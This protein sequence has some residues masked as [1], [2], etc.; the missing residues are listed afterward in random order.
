[1]T[2]SVPE[3]SVLGPILWNSLIDDLLRLPMHDTTKIICFADDIL[4]TT[5]APGLWH[6]RVEIY[7]ALKRVTKWLELK[8]LKVAP[9]K[10]KL[11][12]LTGKRRL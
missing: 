10:T 9:D 8:G 4:I 2:R 6:T 11:M 1:M 3:G 7:G 5:S 12:I